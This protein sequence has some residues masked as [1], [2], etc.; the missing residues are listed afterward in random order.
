MY[1]HPVFPSPSLYV[2]ISVSSVYP[3]FGSSILFRLSRSPL[4]AGFTLTCLFVSLCTQASTKEQLSGGPKGC[5]EG[6]LSV[7][8][9]DCSV[10]S[11]SWSISSVPFLFSLLT[12]PFCCD[13][14][15]LLR[16]SLRRGGRSHLGQERK[17]ERKT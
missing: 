6:R 15:Q 1:I 13:L 4:S 8:C 17:K 14:A 12:Q 9:P 3:S 16:I 11:S 2:F 7:D 5:G 10:S